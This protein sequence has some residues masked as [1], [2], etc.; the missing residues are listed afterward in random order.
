MATKKKTPV[1]PDIVI[2]G[3]QIESLVNKVINDGFKKNNKLKQ[4][5]IDAFYRETHND[6]KGRVKEMVNP[7]GNESFIQ[8]MILDYLLQKHSW[9]ELA[10]MGMKE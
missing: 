8:E 6:I 9:D 2:S 3:K 7:K 5:Y 10:E 4:K 1:T